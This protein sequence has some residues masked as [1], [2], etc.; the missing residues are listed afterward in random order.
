ME[1]K[2]VAFFL[3]KALSDIDR[4]V[5]IKKIK[6]GKTTKSAERHEKLFAY[7]D[8]LESIDEINSTRL[9]KVLKVSSAKKLTPLY[10][11]LISDI[12]KHLVYSELH[13]D[14]LTQ[15][16]LLQKAL[17]DREEVEYIKIL[18]EEVR[19]KIS[20]NADKPLHQISVKKT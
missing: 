19:S 13:K 5:F 8:G 20:Q 17:C 11:E 12:K 2:K 7:L 16:L 1:K 10:S 9:V 3:I 4:S 15:E 6:C 18:H 14:E